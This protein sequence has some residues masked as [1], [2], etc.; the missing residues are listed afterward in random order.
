ML[1]MF[2][3]SVRPQEVRHPKRPLFAFGAPRATVNYAR[4]VGDG[5]E[6]SVVMAP[7]QWVQR[8]MPEAKFRVV[9]EDSDGALQEI[10]G[11]PLAAL[12]QKPNPAYG[13]ATLWAGT[14]LS[15]L[16]SG[17]AYWIKAVNGSGRPVELWYAPHWA[18]TPKWSQDGSDFISHYVY[19]P[20]GVE[21]RLEV[22]DV[23]H[24]RH[25][26]DPEN[27]RLGISPLKGVLREV[28]S[29]MEASAF[30]SALLKNSGV[31]GL[32]VSPKS[33]DPVGPDDVDATK[34]WIEQAFGGNNRGR[35]LVMGTPTEIHEYGYS[36]DKMALSAVR[37]VSEERVAAALGIPAAVLGFGSGMEQTK[38]GATMT[39]LRK[40]AW[41]NGIIPILNVFADEIQ[42]SLMPDFERGG[43]RRR[44]EFDVSKVVAM[45]ED[46]QSIITRMNAAV[47][48]G[49][50]TVAEAREASGL[51]AGEGNDVF[52]RGFNI[53][54]VPADGGP[55]PTPPPSSEEAAL[56]GGETKADRDAPDLS[57]NQQFREPPRRQVEFMR[58][59]VE[60]RQRLEAPFGQRLKAF[61]DELGQDAA[62]QIRP[63]LDPLE[64]NAGDTG[65]ANAVS[66]EDEV[67]VRRV[68]DNLSLEERTQTF[69]QVYEAH[70]LQVAE[71]TAKA[72]EIIGL[73][74]DLPD[75]VAR[76][77][78]Q[79]G[80]RRAG[81]VDLADDTKE[82][83]FDIIAEARADGVGVDEIVRR[84]GNTAGAGPWRSADVRARVTARTETKF[85]QNVSS[86]E[87][88]REAGVERFMLHDGRFG[89]PRSTPSH[90]ARDGTIVTADEAVALRE[91]EHPNGT[92]SFS[93]FL[94]ATDD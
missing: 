64:A 66:G 80:G 88:G 2:R 17:N 84:V 36:P 26:I 27:P 91:S 9:E 45:Q 5:T 86:V 20:G 70:Y 41:Q 61:F 71:E 34:G 89:L 12:M 76:T 50:A 31:P 93:P 73:A 77:V 28:C 85:A 35:P 47:Q 15:Y 87:R 56:G 21:Q 83:L 33:G 65:E 40:L 63:L 90:I 57:Q 3:K 59:L 78:V 23:V 72:G 94:E 92:M 38:V 42:R 24:F 16:T 48:G 69:R 18:I 58:V 32:V 81:L 29:D 11:H 54:E 25:G 68:L 30:T 62:N 55:A 82:V 75:A 22:S 19:N 6:S 37:N 52:L 1:G 51:D 39:E 67:T 79:A 7:I 10:D 74:T 4:E 8:A 53:L 14:L 60:Q 49:W 13:E 46:Q 43:S 44:A